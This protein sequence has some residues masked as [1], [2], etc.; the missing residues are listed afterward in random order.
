MKPK[1]MSPYEFDKEIVERE[2]NVFFYNERGNVVGIN[3][4]AYA[5][6]AQKLLNEIEKRMGR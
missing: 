2:E 1:G 6:A 4:A 3:R 5:F